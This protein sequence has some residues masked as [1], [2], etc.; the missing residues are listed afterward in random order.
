MELQLKI[1]DVANI[2]QTSGELTVKN[3]ENATIENFTCTVREPSWFTFREGQ[4]ASLDLK[5][6]EERTFLVDLSSGEGSKPILL[7]AY[8]DIDGERGSKSAYVRAGS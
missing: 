3:L 8:G 4:F 5:P 6:Y 7:T 1:S 2:V